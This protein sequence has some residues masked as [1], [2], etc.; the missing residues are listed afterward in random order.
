MM[1]WIALGQTPRKGEKSQTQEE[2]GN[3]ILLELLWDKKAGVILISKWDNSVILSKVQGRGDRKNV[4]ARSWEMCS[5]KM[6]SGHDIAI[7]FM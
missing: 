3:S 6:F 7:A 5:K 2:R 4:R 1:R